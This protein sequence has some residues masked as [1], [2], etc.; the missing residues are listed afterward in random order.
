[1]NY[2]NDKKV[3]IPLNMPGQIGMPPLKG[4]GAYAPSLYTQNTSVILF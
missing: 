3:E 4:N 2:L 1:M